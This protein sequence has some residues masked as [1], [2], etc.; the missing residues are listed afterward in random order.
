MALIS[1]QQKIAI[2]AQ[3][4]QLCLM[5]LITLSVGGFRGGVTEQVDLRHYPLAGPLDAPAQLGIRNH[6][7]GATQSGDV[8]GLARGHQRQAA[9]GD[10]GPQGGDRGVFQSGFEYQVTVDLVGADQ[11]I[12]AQHQLGQTLQFIAPVEGAARVVRIAE[13]Q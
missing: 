11:Q 7:K 10:L 12:M 2:G 3:V 5:P 4:V 8:V 9:G 1:P 13:Q 6:G